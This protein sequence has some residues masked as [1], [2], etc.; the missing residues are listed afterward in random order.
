M[1]TYPEPSQTFEMELSAKAVDDIQSLTIF[2]KSFI[3]DLSQGSE[4][5]SENNKQNSGAI[6]FI[7]QK[8]KSSIS[9]D[10]FHH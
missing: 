8:I 2:T 3:L 7:S 6:V 10:F 4:Y 9:A 5:A 1:E